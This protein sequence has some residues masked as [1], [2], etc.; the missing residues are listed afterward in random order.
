MQDITEAFEI[1]RAQKCKTQV[2]IYNNDKKIQ[3]EELL[4]G[5]LQ[6][7]CFL[8]DTN[9]LPLVKVEFPIQARN[10]KT[11]HWVVTLDPSIF[12]E[13]WL[14]Q[15]LYSDWFRVR[16]TEFIGIRQC[17]TCGAFGH[18]AKGC[19]DRDKPSIC[20]NFSQLIT[21]NHSCMVPNCK[22]A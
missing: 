17:R 19:D 11:R 2:I 8:Y 22:I 10:R 1:T 5:L 6:K 20:D 14:K 16:F 3:A 21:E 18:T 9:N 15:S 12:K 13:L 7:N 4:A